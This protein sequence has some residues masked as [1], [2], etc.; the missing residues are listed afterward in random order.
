MKTKFIVCL[1]ILF[2]VGSLVGFSDDNV[3]N[4]PTLVINPPDWF[5]TQTALYDATPVVTEKPKPKNTKTPTPT[6]VYDPYPAPE[7]DFWLEDILSKI[8][9]LFR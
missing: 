9:I 3:V 5:D 8:M 6:P 4:E 2:L 7:T 1:V